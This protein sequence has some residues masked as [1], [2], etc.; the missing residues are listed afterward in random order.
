MIPFRASKSACAGTPWLLAALAVHLLAAPGVLQAA[1]GAATA[2]R[3]LVSLSGTWQCEPGEPDG[4]PARWTHAVPVPGLV[5]LC[6]PALKWEDHQYF[7]HRT[8]FRL[9]PGSEK[10][11]A[12]IRID[13]SQFGSEVWLN[14]KRLGSYNGC[15]T[16]H[17]YD[18]DDAIH[19]RA[20]NILLVRV[21]K[22]ETLPPN[23][24]AGGDS[25]KLSFIP[26]IWGDVSVILSGDPRI[27]LVRVTPR[28]RE[29]TAEATVS[30]EMKSGPARTITVSGV[31]AEKKGRKI[32]SPKMSA[33][34]AL[35]PGQEKEVV[36]KLPLADLRTWSPDDPFLYELAASL[37]AGGEE[38]DRV[39]TTFGMREFRIEGA[40]FYLNGKKVFLRG[41]NIAFHRFLS[42]KDRGRL[43]WDEGWVKKVMGGKPKQ[44]GFNY[45]RFHLGHAYNRWY[46]VADEYG[47]LIQDE[48]MGFGRL[49]ASE[50]LLREEF[51]RWIEDNY[52]HPCIVLWD[53][54]NEIEENDDAVV[55]GRMLKNSLVPRLKKLDPTRPWEFV[56]FE[57]EHPYIYSLGPVLNDA[58]FG[59]AR[60]IDDI[61]D[62]RTPTMLNEFVWFWLRGDGKPTGHTDEVVPRW[63]GNGS[64]AQERLAFQAFLATE[65]VEQFRRMRVD[66]IAPFVYVGPN[67]GATANWFLGNIRDLRPK[68]I[69]AALK[70]AL[71]PFG[72]SVELWDRHFFT[73][74]QRRINVYVFNDFPEAKAGSVTCRIV[75]GQDVLFERVFPVEVEPGGT[76]VLP[77]DW[78][79]PDQPGR[80]I[81]QAELASDDPARPVAH[82]RKVA[83]VF[84]QVGAPAE[85]KGKRI[86][87]HDPDEEILSF[88]KAR[89]VDAVPFRET[90]LQPGD[91]FVVGEG[92]LKEESY[93][94]RLAEIGAW[95]EEEGGNLVLVEPDYGVND[96]R[97]VRVA[98][99]VELVMRDRTAK[100]R[101]GYDS[102]VFPT[103]EKDPFWRG[104]AREHLDFFNGG[105]GGIMVSDR[106]IVFDR[107][108][109]PRAS[110]G[111]Y[112]GTAAL[113]EMPAGKGA[114]VVS[115]LQVRGRLVPRGDGADLYA[116]RADPVAQR[117]L[118]NLLATYARYR[119]RGIAPATGNVNASS[120]TEGDLR[121][122]YAVDGDPAT[123]WSSAYSDPQWILYDL[124]ARKTIRGV[125]LSWE[126][127]FGKEYKILVS[128]DARNWT[129]VF[130]E[131]E[132]NGEVDEISFAPV[133]ARYVCM[134]G[135]RRD[136]GWG[137]SLFEFSVAEAPP[138]AL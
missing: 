99:S 52:N 1:D 128:D 61:R 47:L 103:R 116:L 90:R 64:T 21:G 28:L 95:L 51:T 112:L 98:A 118:L 93:L 135:L 44:L 33:E 131:K 63:L 86:V 82:S 126:R 41:S 85:L 8:S 94:S 111:L 110:S 105:F 120:G 115:R 84:E 39:R 48:W 22:K 101:G 6:E 56:D 45:F 124:G 60:S 43:P 75:D 70:N 83:H 114:V 123:R 54:V 66:G 17:E 57:E 68:P 78:V 59:F 40:D 49:N 96:E 130:H 29:K 119:T 121:A 76:K 113:M 37:S 133:S 92:G 132:G 117:Y 25:E 13:Q 106:D 20:E 88:L 136:T 55:E 80:Y 3:V 125:K 15:Y 69:L 50:D 24:A 65:L 11:R 53:P 42:D 87:V 74:E 19:Y 77:V 38:T 71:S 104:I 100:G 129:T 89:G 10:R 137:Y 34:V 108:F 27:R 30:V 138:G 16:S 122:A 73:K 46:D 31:V 5:D 58:R 7:W 12:R 9:P 109:L 91:I 107:P 2:P 14:G 127:A 32:A 81:V 18:A 26:G 67:A 72:V 79:F 102:A 134:M 62:S 35:R 36:L 97:P 23:N 4:P